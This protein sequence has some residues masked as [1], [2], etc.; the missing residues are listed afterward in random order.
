MIS[1]IPNS[2]SAPQNFHPMQ[3]RSK[4]GISKPKTNLSLSVEHEDGDPTSF[5]KAVRHSTWRQA[6]TEEFNAF[7]ENNTWE[8]VPRTPSMNVVGYKWIYTTKYASEGSV[9]RYKARLVALGNH[10]QVGID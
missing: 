9:D 8:L 7:L 5:S 6:M 2:S 1:T 3:T 10:Q 4:L